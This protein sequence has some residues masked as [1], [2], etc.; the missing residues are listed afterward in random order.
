MG[1]KLHRAAV[2]FTSAIPVIIFAL[3][4][5]QSIAEQNAYT[6]LKGLGMAVIFGGCLW[7]VKK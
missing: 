2:A 6:A 1:K 3:S 7:D 5:V 4:L